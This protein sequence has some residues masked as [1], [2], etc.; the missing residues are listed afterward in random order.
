M[1]YCNA[2]ASGVRRAICVGRGASR[3]PST[4]ENKILKHLLHKT[5]GPTFLK[6][7]MEHNLTPGSLNRKT[8]FGRISKMRYY[9]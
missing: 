3:R 1:C 6:F 7:H 5:T 8:V 2:N 4:L 9:K